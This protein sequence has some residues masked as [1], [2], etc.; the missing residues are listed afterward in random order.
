MSN[1]LAYAGAAVF[2]CAILLLIKES[3]R[4][5]VVG[6]FSGRWHWIFLLPAG[7]LGFNAFLYWFTRSWDGEKFFQLVLYF[8]APTTLCAA[9]YFLRPQANKWLISFLELSL[10]LFIWLPDEFNLLSL[11]WKICGTSYPFGGAS[12]LIFS[13]IAFPAFLKVNLKLDWRFGWKDFAWI[14]GVFVALFVL[15]APVGLAIQFIHFGLNSKI[16]KWFLVFPMIWLGI[17]LV[18]ELIFRAMIQRILMEILGPFLGLVAGALV[19]GLAHVNNVAG[20]YDVPNWPYVGF[21]TIAGLG[22]GL[23]YYRRNLQSS[24]TLHT[25]VDFIWWLIFKSGK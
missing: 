17:A 3:V 12:V 22:Y 4:D 25:L 23:V 7:L 10:I 21:A 13:L 16:E 2:V 5:A 14:L 1:F 19:F 6:W 9:V 24:A 8:A 11:S 20:I 15:I 18:E